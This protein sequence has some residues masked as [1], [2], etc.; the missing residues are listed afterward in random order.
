MCLLLLLLL[1][2]LWG[3]CVLK[4]SKAPILTPL[5]LLW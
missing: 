1:L 4:P 3:C 5:Q 2:L